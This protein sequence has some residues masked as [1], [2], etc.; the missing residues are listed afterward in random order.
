MTRPCK[1]VSST[2]PPIIPWFLRTLP[3][4]LPPACHGFV[5]STVR[6]RAAAGISSAFFSNTRSIPR[7]NAKPAYLLTGAVPNRSGWFSFIRHISARDDIPPV[8]RGC[9]CYHAP[10]EREPHYA[11]MVASPGSVQPYPHRF[12]PP[13]ALPFYLLPR[14]TVSSP[15]DVRV[16]AL[17]CGSLLLQTERC[18]PAHTFIAAPFGS[19]LSWD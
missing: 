16:V 10:R 5:C 9:C 14:S 8:T 1:P 17:G 18:Q 12:P 7:E 4:L 15:L 3:Y 13:R 6:V 2:A 19:I 11:A